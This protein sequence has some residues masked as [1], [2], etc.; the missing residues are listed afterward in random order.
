VEIFIFFN[1]SGIA[2]LT[3]HS[4]KRLW[5]LLSGISCLNGNFLTKVSL[6]EFI[7]MPLN[8]L[9]WNSHI[10]V[11]M[12]ESSCTRYLVVF[13]LLFILIIIMSSAVIDFCLIK[14]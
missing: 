1:S 12:N 4:G 10:V 8:C 7:I 9:F 6:L 5:L 14:L 11:N 13:H 3:P 2:C